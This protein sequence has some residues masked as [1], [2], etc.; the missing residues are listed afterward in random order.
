MELPLLKGKNKA[1][2]VK[3]QVTFLMDKMD[4]SKGKKEKVQEQ[5]KQL[6]TLISDKSMGKSAQNRVQALT[7]NLKNEID[8]IKKKIEE[9]KQEMKDQQ[10]ILD[11]RKEEDEK[12]KK[13]IQV[14]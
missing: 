5:E 9:G 14:K 8:S 11:S 4:Q 2:V 12:M 13:V 10:K 7:N 1:G 3:V 6:Q